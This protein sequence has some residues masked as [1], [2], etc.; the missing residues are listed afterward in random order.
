VP[1]DA[2]RPPDATA[3]EDSRLL[4]RVRAGDE[5]AFARLVDLHGASLRRVARMYV[6]NPAS[7]EEV[8]QETWLGLLES[9]E[10]FEGRA[11]LRTWIFRILVNCARKRARRDR[12]DLPFSAAWAPG[13]ELE[14]S[15][16]PDRFLGANHRGKGHWALPPRS[17]DELPEERLLSAEATAKVQT[18]ID[19]LPDAQREV[20]TLRDVEGWTASE[21]C[22]VAGLSDTNQR[23]LLHRARSKVR[24]ALESY[25]EDEQ[26]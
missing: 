6:S 21:V 15:V 18:A 13:D 10:R 24:R 5:E 17:W 3:S 22:N 23:V 9:L 1:D 11:S 4:E 8:V 19:S 25:L 7:A 26:G 14:A 20:I 12:R 2:D 16:D